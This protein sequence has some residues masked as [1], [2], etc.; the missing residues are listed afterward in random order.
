MNEQEL[1]Q[2]MRATMASAT[3]PPPM[4]ETVVLDA[5]RRTERRR[6]ARWAGVGSAVA[7][8]A[9]VGFAVVVV[10][11]TSGAGGPVGI[12]SGAP[13]TLQTPPKATAS[14]TEPSWPDGQTDRTATSGPRFDQ[15]VML[16]DALRAVAPP[17]L[18]TPEDLQY[19]DPAYVGGGPLRYHQAQYEDTIHGTQVWEYMAA[20]PV[21]KG[22]G[23][24]ELLVEVTT[25]GS[26][27][28]GD[29]CDLPPL[30]GLEGSCT[31]QTVAGRRVGVFTATGGRQ[32]FETWA[33]YRHEDGTLVYVAQS[34][35]YDGSGKPGLGGAPMPVRR[36]AELATDARFRLD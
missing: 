4:N 27:V 18:G 8:V 3:V 12:G 28:A 20:L 19:E 26:G 24:G 31:E 32:D 14:G 10:A 9:V 2:A 17:G 33:A 29:G 21:T 6:R 25:A 11:V 1:R 15:G 34:A 22:A 5:A 13:S 30:W 16:L 7:A 36:L 35:T 23:V